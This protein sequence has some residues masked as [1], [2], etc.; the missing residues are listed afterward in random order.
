MS[1][2]MQHPANGVAWS[3]VYWHMQ[4][5]MLHWTRT[6]N[7][8]SLLALLRLVIKLFFQ[9]TSVAGHTI[10]QVKHACLC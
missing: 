8:K 7:L 9:R 4:Y 1:Y 5:G 6:S 10:K 2:I 3:C